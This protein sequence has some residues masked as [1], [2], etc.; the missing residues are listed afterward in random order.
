MLPFYSDQ[1]MWGPQGDP[2]KE[3]PRL[4]PG[5]R[6]ADG[7]IFMGDSPELVLLSELARV[8]DALRPLDARRNELLAKLAEVNPE[9][10]SGVEVSTEAAPAAAPV[11]AKKKA[12]KSA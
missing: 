8:E 12:A 7:S 10:Y 2:T 1:T 9:K 11:S 5:D 3:R 4:K 6:M